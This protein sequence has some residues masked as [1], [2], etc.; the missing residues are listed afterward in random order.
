MDLLPGCKGRV[1]VCKA[2]EEG[3]E[4]GEEGGEEGEPLPPPPPI[5]F[6]S[7]PPTP[8]SKKKGAKKLTKKLSSVNYVEDRLDQLLAAGFVLIFTDGSLE[9]HPT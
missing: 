8:V 4:E 1:E 3:G 9:Q 2:G 6:P 7:V 5:G